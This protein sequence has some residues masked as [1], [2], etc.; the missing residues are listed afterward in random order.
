[1]NIALSPAYPNPFN[2]E[3]RIDFQVTGNS[4]ALQLQIYNVKGELLN[5]LLNSNYL[6]GTYSTVWDG[7]N[8]IGE[9]VNS[10]VYLVRL[11]GAGETLIQR[12]TLLK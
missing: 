12:V 8:A 7:R 5:T 6:P 2:P 9:A 11:A 4:Q 3:L 10:G 1:M